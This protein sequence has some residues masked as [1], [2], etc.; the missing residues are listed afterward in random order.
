MADAP[1]GMLGVVFVTQRLGLAAFLQ[2]A[3][4]DPARTDR[5]DTNLRPEA[6]RH[7]VGEG[8]DAAL[9]GG[10]GFAVRLGLQRAAGG[11]IDDAAAS[12]AQMTRR[13]LGGQ[14]AA[15]QAGVEYLMPALE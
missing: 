2:G 13:M 4:V 5:I 3:D 11:Q 7:G 8:D 9:A 10:V 6:H 12:L 15:G 14:E 1:D